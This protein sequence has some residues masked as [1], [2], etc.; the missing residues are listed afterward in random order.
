MVTKRRVGGVSSRIG[1]E[2][3]KDTHDK[4]ACDE[5]PHGAMKDAQDS[6]IATLQTMIQQKNED[7]FDLND[8]LD[9]IMAY[10]KKLNSDDPHTYATSYTELTSDG[11]RIVEEI[12]EG[13]QTLE[14]VHTTYCREAFEHI[15]ARY[16]DNPNNPHLEYDHVVVLSHCLRCCLHS[17]D[18]TRWAVVVNRH[19]ATMDMTPEIA[20][21]AFHTFYAQHPALFSKASAQIARDTSDLEEFYDASEPEDDEDAPTPG[22]IMRFMDDLSL[23][24]ES[25]D[26][27]ENSVKQGSPTT[28]ATSAANVLLDASKLR[29]RYGNIVENSP[30]ATIGAFQATYAACHAI[31]DTVSN[32]MLVNFTQRFMSA[33]RTILVAFLMGSRGVVA[34]FADLVNI[35]C[36]FVRANVDVFVDALHVLIWLVEGV[37]RI[38]VRIGGACETITSI[39]S[40]KVQQISDTVERMSKSLPVRALKSLV[41]TAVRVVMALIWVLGEICRLLK[42]QQPPDRTRHPVRKVD[43]TGSSL[44]TPDATVATPK[45]ATPKAAASFADANTHRTPDVSPAAASPCPDGLKLCEWGKQKNWCVEDLKYCNSSYETG[46]LDPESRLPVDFKRSKPVNNDGTRRRG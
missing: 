24:K 37:C 25:M 6:I 28:I 11:R 2:S 40:K 33:M 15:R 41:N 14:D 22:E 17:E 44:W 7:T 18:A 19:L 20:T 46:H 45:A 12:Y 30:N 39:V 23:V 34:L 4:V 3:P 35:L 32:T 31:I 8:A 5:C 9:Q 26:D 13:K 36:R 29:F 16:G 38:G 42:E 21:N 1:K 43:L 27:L 10:V